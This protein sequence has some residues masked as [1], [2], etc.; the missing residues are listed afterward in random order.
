MKQTDVIPVPDNIS[1]ETAAQAIVN[2]VTAYAMLDEVNVP[3]G[4]YLLQTAGASVIGRIIIQFAKVRGVKT[5]SLV[6][7]KEQIEELK[8]IGADEVL[9]T[10]D[11]TNI[12]KE[13]KRITNGKFAYGAFDSVGGELGVKIAQSV[14]DNGHIFLYGAL[15]GLTV[16]TS[17]HALLF[18]NVH[19]NGFW[20]TKFLREAGREKVLNTFMNVFELLGN[21][22]TPLAGKKFPLEKLSEAL[23]YS[24][25]EARG[26]KVLLTHNTKPSKL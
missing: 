16:T 20:L 7:R 11:G 18:R 13:V 17:T 21:G 3:K 22:I 12:Y 19:Y 2:P 15:D 25:K 26:G 14:R 6:R 8:A 4:E 5:I 24:E 10:E 23:E 9:C 1:D